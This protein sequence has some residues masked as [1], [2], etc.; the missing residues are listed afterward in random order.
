M[1]LA[2]G[3]FT[4]SPVDLSGNPHTITL[5]GILSGPG[6]L[7]VTNGGTLVLNAANNYTGNTIVSAGKLVLGNSSALPAATGLTIGGNGS[8]GTVDLDGTARC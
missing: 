7:L 4:F 1:T 6:N 3:T 8:A 5:D 2:G